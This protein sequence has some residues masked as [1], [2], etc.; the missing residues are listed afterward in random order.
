MTVSTTSN[1]IVYTGNGVTT[2]F[3]FP[4]K[5][6][7]T[8]DLKVYVGGVLQTTG[9]TVGTPSDTG[10]NVTFSSVPANGAAIII[11]SDP[12]R[13]QGTSLPST[14]PFPAKSVETMSDKLTLLVQRLYDLASRSLTLNDADSTTANTTL[15][16]PAANQIIGWNGS[17][18]GLQN[19][20]LA[21]LATSIAYGTARSDIFTGDGTTRTFTLSASP[22]AQA[23]LDV[24]IAGVTQ[25]PGTDYTWSTGTSVV[26]SSAPPLG[27][28]VLVRYMQ[29]LAQG[30]SDSA[31]A[32]FIQSGTGAVARVAQDKMREWVSLK[33]FGAVGD[34]VT[35]DTAAV[36]T[37]INAASPTGTPI[38]VVGYCKINGDIAVP[39]TGVQFVGRDKYR[40]GFIL[41]PQSAAITGGTHAY[42]LADSA[43]NTSN[44]SFRS[45][46]FKSTYNSATW[47]GSTV[48]AVYQ[49]APNSG[50]THSNIRFEDCYFF[51]LSFDG[52]H[53]APHVGGVV[54]DI[55]IDRCVADVTSLQYSSRITNLYQ[56]I[57]EWIAYPSHGS[58]YGLKQILNLRVT[59]SYARGYRTLA[60]VKRGHSKFIVANCITEDM[61]DCHFSIDGSF[62][63]IFSNLVGSQA[64]AL[65]PNKNFI[66]CQGED[67]VISNWEYNGTLGLGA[68]AAVLLE[69]YAYPLESS[70]AYHQPRRVTIQNGKCSGINQNAVRLQDTIDCVVDGL[71]VS[72]N[73]QSAVAIEHP[74]VTSNGGAN[75]A[76]PIGNRVSG[77][78][79]GQNVGVFGVN[80]AT[81]A[82]RTLI[83]DIKGY[84][85]KVT[86]SYAYDPMFPDNANPNPQ[87]LVTGGVLTGFG[88][89][90][91][92]SVANSTTSPPDSA[93]SVLIT[94]TAPPSTALVSLG[95]YIKVS[96]SNTLPDGTVQL[97]DV[98]SVRSSVQLG[99]ATMA[100]ILFQ[101]FDASGA[102]ISNDFQALPGL[103]NSAF[104]E[105]ILSHTATASNCA[106]VRVCMMPT[107]NYNGAFAGTSYW[108]KVVVSKRTA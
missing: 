44:V 9:Y 38:L 28:K 106:Y 62:F 80:L 104:T 39:A 13:L 8:A 51:D 71:D 14:G 72:N 43:T 50:V 67:I 98:V 88:L 34:G 59:N 65:I 7:A 107:S 11:L 21:D 85:G 2:A 95:H 40:D 36:Q 10:A 41:A 60:D 25:L 70:T 64:S 4:Y 22:G 55:L 52:V 49:S 16:T 87:M 18:T 54:R 58:T 29:G 97:G 82:V 32:A 83:G 3:A 35:D 12:A 77:I 27:A 78:R 94:A 91:G 6:I 53:I 24:A 42:F 100:G 75:S 69:A 1:R 57:I 86:T 15:P 89:S 66:D 102:F 96:P 61:S 30:A 23:N 5:F 19:V 37:A 92:V 81:Q 84:L 103:S 79:G 108:A 26:F 93:Q 47:T 101:E 17:G 33:D 73:T 74:S 90:S 63:G 105:N 46:G 31:S 68:V 48:F 76:F 99:T 20:P 45:I 56:G